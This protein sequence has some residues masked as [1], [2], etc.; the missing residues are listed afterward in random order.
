[1]T[2]KIVEPVY[3]GVIIVRQSLTN[4]TTSHRL[5]LN[6][7][8]ALY[9]A[10]R[11]LVLLNQPAEPSVAIH[12]HLGRAMQQRTPFIHLVQLSSMQRSTTS[13]SLRSER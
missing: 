7:D 11:L 8:M 4:R 1:M 2:H 9:N 3:G 12:L 13:P 6:C 5:F 10:I